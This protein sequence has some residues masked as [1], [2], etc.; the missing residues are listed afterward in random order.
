MYL[1]RQNITLLATSDKN[2]VKYLGKIDDEN[3]LYSTINEPLQE[4]SKDIDGKDITLFFSLPILFLIMGFILK[5]GFQK[6]NARYFTDEEESLVKLSKS[7]LKFVKYH[8]KIACRQC[9]FFN[10]NNYLK[11]AVHPD[12]VLKKEARNCLDY[13]KKSD[14]KNHN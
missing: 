11:C 7:K 10:K 14:I 12:R 9:H 6:I 3:H 1:N 8:P 13:Q 2:F 5:I 4:Q